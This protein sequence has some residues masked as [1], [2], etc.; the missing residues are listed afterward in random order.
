MARLLEEQKEAGRRYLE[1]LHTA[2]MSAGIYALPAGAADTQTPHAEEEIYYV[3]RGRAQFWRMTA[4]G[5]EDDA[6]EPGTVLYVSAGKEHRFHNITEDLLLLVCF[7]PPEGS[8]AD[9]AK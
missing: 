2:H 7:A 5:P 1:F 8:R 9:S 3:I 4:A 6:V